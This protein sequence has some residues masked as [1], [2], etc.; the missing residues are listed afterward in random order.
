MSMFKSLQAMRGTITLFHDPVSR[1]STSILH[2]LQQHQPTQSGEHK[3]E[4]H[5]DIDVNTTSIPTPEEFKYFQESLNMHPNAKKSL[6]AA[7]P[8]LTKNCKVIKDLQDLEYVAN[9]TFKRPLVVDWDHQL[10][11]VTENGLQKILDQYNGRDT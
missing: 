4:Y 6:F 9:T 3:G 8:D 1:T 10:L 7:Y 5:Y 2:K 11:A